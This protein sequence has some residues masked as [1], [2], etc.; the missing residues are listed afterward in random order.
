MLGYIHNA[1]NTLLEQVN[2]ILVYSKLE[3]GKL[4]LHKKEYNFYNL[5]KEQA[6]ICLM[7]LN[8]KPVDFVVRMESE[9]PEM[10]IGDE[11]CGR[12]SRICCPMQRS[13]PTVDPLCVPS[14]VTKRRTVR[15][16]RYTEAWKIPV[17]E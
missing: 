3:A 16:Y 11:S 8:E 15:S 1:G 10:M 2:T 5:L 17:W 4:T 14:A 6:H 12:S 7:N 13:L 9:F